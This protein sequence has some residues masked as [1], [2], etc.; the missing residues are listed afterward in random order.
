MELRG[1]TERPCLGEVLR[2]RQIH[3]SERC[4]DSMES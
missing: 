2:G 3:Q 1:D 4:D